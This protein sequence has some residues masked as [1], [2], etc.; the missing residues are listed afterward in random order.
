M[1]VVLLLIVCSHDADVPSRHHRMAAENRRSV[2]H[3]HPRP[4]F[5]KFDG[6]NQSRQAGANHNHIGIRWRNRNRVHASVAASG[7]KQDESHQAHHDGRGGPGSHP[8]PR[9]SWRH[10]IHRIGRCRIR[11]VGRVQSTAL[12]ALIFI[13]GSAT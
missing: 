3:D 13:V 5:G 1:N 8:F 10:I 4:A 12:A 9:M 7:R 11:R 2:D 6:R